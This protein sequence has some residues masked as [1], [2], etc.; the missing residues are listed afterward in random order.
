MPSKVDSKSSG[1]E[2][3]MASLSSTKQ[4]SMSSL[5][6]SG[7][8]RISSLSGCDQLKLSSFSDTDQLK[9]S[10]ASDDKEL[11][12]QHN[13]LT[14]PS[15]KVQLSSTPHSIFEFSLDEHKVSKVSIYL[16]YIW[17][18]GYVV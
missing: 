8:S 12:E 16:I 17:V 11:N 6:G 4:L 2:R 14:V 15:G 18:V 13:R 5:S 1:D 10:F 9:M 3:N 7:E